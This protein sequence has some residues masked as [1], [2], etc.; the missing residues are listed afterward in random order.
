MSDNIEELEP[1][2]EEEAI[3]QGYVPTELPNIEEILANMPEAQKILFLTQFLLL[4]RHAKFHDL[5]EEN[6]EIRNYVDD[7]NQSIDIQVHL[8]PTKPQPKVS[9]TQM[10]K[11]HSVLLKYGMQDKASK[12]LKE[13]TDILKEKDTPSILTASE[14]DMNAAIAD[15]R[16]QEDLKAKL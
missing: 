16:K 9:G 12:V 5:I 15:A 7:E 11:I 1:E 4:M 14:G 2:T 6:F 8:K 10:M 3:A 13:I